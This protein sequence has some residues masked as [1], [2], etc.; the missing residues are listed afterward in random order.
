[1]GDTCLD[2]EDA[3]AVLTDFFAATGDELAALV[4]DRGPLPR[5]GAPAGTSLPTVARTG[6]LSTQVGVLD[7]HITGT[8]YASLEASGAIDAIARDNG[9]NGPWVFPLR[10]ALRDGLADLSD[11][12]IMTIAQRWGEDAG[13]VA[14]GEDFRILEGLVTD[15]RGLARAARTSGRDLY[16]WVSP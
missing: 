4:V 14:R 3:V 8:P 2:L 1:M 13:M 9:P 16:L 7:G 15:L 11:G 12:R 6:I 10:R 5:D